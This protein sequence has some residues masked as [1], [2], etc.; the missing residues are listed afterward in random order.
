M[1]SSQ[2][3][4]PSGLEF[5]EQ[6]LKVIEEI[7][8]KLKVRDAD[9][10]FLLREASKKRDQRLSSL[11][12]PKTITFS[13]KVFIPITTLCR[14]RCHYCTFVNTP[15]QAKRKGVPLFMSED[16]VLSVAIQGARLGCKE[17]LFTLGDRPEER[18][19]EARDWLSAHGFASTLDYI[20]HLARRVMQE[21]GL[22]PHLNPGVLSLSELQKLK[23][24][25]PSMGMMLET[26]SRSLWETPGQAHFGSPDKNPQIRLQ[27]LEDAGLAQVPFTTGLL[28]GIG[29]TIRDRAESLFLLS[30]IA[31]KFGNIQEVIIQNFRAKPS[32]VMRGVPDAEWQEYLAAVATARLVLDSSVAIQAPPNLADPDHVSELLDAGVDDWGGVSPLTPDHVNPERPWPL[33]QELARKTS[34]AGFVLTER[35]TAQPEFVQNAENWMDLGVLP[36]VR[37]LSD[38]KSGLATD[39][40]D[41]KTDSP[42]DEKT[43]FA[44]TNNERNILKKLESDRSKVSNLEF[45]QLLEYEGDNLHQLTL[46]ADESRRN[47]VGDVATFVNNRSITLDNFSIDGSENPERW[48][49]QDLIE[50]ATEAVLRGNTEICL[51]GVAKGQIPDLVH[52]QILMAITDVA[53]EIHVHAFRVSEIVA[54]ARSRNENLERYL[55][56]LCDSGLSSIPGT[57]VLIPSDRVKN[58]SVTTPISLETWA[59]VITQAHLLGLNST[60]IAAF[61]RGETAL[62]RINYLAEISEIQNKTGGFTEFIP[63]PISKDIVHLLPNR[64]VE[65]E[66]IAMTAVSRLFFQGTIKNIQ[67]AWPRVGEEIA[68]SLLRSG[69]NDLGGTLD[70]GVLRTDINSVQGLGASPEILE[71]L[72]KKAGRSIRQRNTAYGNV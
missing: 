8:L 57:G 39:V 42:L 9:F 33:I 38:S 27:V 53:P 51:Q 31:N 29:E 65:E 49:T 25:S 15:S 14:D 46:I 13:K 4:T 34:E 32:T 55:Q 61:G 44:N 12:R 52:S 11:G 45:A 60:S 3:P 66:N 37:R 30:K 17:A 50:I 22:L 2:L 59:N 69:A 26:T 36:F 7:E 6:E 23:P 1:N 35:I 5:T 47:Y 72:A 58:T 54:G 71:R 56:F 40:H 63:L 20:E 19:P 68:I 43:W 16:Q 48:S 24:V 21:T 64:S 70:T 62:D 41:Y 10:N 28:I 18:W 67:A